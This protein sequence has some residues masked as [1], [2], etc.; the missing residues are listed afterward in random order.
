MSEENKGVSPA[1]NPGEGSQTASQLPAEGGSN[2]E[3]GKG[4]AAEFL[5]R[6][7]AERWKDDILR[8]T[9]SLTDKAA[10]RMDKR[11]QEELSKVDDV[12]KIQRESGIE[13][14][15]QQEKEMRRSV[16][17]KVL[18]E[19]A[20][21]EMPGQQTNLTPSQ[22]MSAV[23]PEAAAQAA[24]LSS[25]A[26]DIFKEV[27]ITVDTEDP[28]ASLVDQSNPTA[29]LKTIRAAAEKKKQRVNTPAEARVASL[30]K[31]QP[32]DLEAEYLAKKKD[33]HGDVDAL[34][35]LKREYRAKGLQID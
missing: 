16:Y 5:T 1:G 24:L 9:Q 11:L 34:F 26:D 8:Q 13:I 3:S 18:K 12:L 4:T 15:A 28:E 19:E 6:E 14:T 22:N 2:V 35:A 23:S 20:N 27:G 25:L 21:Q 10:S 31:G 29:F 7:E 30:T 33:I 32:S 17:D